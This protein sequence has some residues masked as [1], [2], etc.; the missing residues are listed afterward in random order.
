[1]AKL[2]V[3]DATRPAWQAIRTR[4]LVMLKAL[5]AAVAACCAALLMIAGQ[6]QAWAVPLDGAALRQADYAHVSGV[7]PAALGEDMPAGSAKATQ[8]KI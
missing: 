1:M 2:G 5:I 4:N 7:T 8:N 6:A 3:S